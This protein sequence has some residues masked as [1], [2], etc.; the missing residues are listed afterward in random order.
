MKNKFHLI[1]VLVLALIRSSGVFA[2]T[3]STAAGTIGVAEPTGDVVSWNATTQPDW[4]SILD[5]LAPENKTCGN[6]PIGDLFTVTPDTT[7][8]GD[9]VDKVYLANS[10]NLTKTYQ[11]L[12]MELYLEGSVEAGE[13]PNYRLLTLENGMAT[14]RLEDGG[15]GNHTLSVSGGDYT[16]NSR[17]PSEWEAGWTV[18][19]EFYCEVTQR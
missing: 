19:P 8:S 7:Y 2:Y 16:L 9:L 17:E 5:D 6:V 15:S 14:F 1:T 3:Y 11:S 4:D 12:N 13:T 10:G 18:S